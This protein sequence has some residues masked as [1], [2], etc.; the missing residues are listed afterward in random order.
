MTP[1]VLHHELGV[2]ASHMTE[3]FEPAATFQ[4]FFTLMLLINC[5]ELSKHKG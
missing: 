1:L 3:G 4:D 2:H 5:A